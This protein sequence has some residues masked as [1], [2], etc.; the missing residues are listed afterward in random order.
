MSPLTTSS[1]I[2]N[3]VHKSISSQLE[4]WKTMLVEGQLYEFEQDLCQRMTDLY[5]VVCE[6]LLP[7]A[8][9]AAVEDLV[10]EGKAAGG[11]KIVVRPLTLRIASGRQIEVKSPYVKVPA[12]GW[13]GS[14]QLLCKHWGVI[15]GASPALY[16]KVGFCC[17]LGPS[18]DLAHQALR[19]F[20]V[21][22][23]FSDSQYSQKC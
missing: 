13:S 16:D 5:N 12:E 2:A 6:E 7:Q 22:V 21:E 23:C 20:G 14:C 18:Y 10:R 19:K 11:R 3:F 15:G 9:E 17:A 1:K 4:H 8:A